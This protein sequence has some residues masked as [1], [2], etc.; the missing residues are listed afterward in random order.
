MVLF[1]LLIAG[2]IGFVYSM[3][4]VA[5]LVTGTT[6]MMRRGP[7]AGLAA[8]AGTALGFSIYAAAAIIGLGLFQYFLRPVHLAIL[9]IVLGVVFIV[10]SGVFMKRRRRRKPKPKS[11][12]PDQ[13]RGIWPYFATNLALILSGPQKI[14]Y[15]TGVFL[16]FKLHISSVDVK[17]AIPFLTLL[18]SL[19]FWSVYVLLVSKEKERLMN[20]RVVTIGLEKIHHVAHY[21]IFISTRN[22]IIE[23]RLLRKTWRLLIYAMPVFGVLL[24]IQGGAFFFH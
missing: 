10:T 15:I 9:E 22:F 24:I 3:M 8:G 20:L 12:A 4:S 14:A 7:V 18:G 5:T 11:K 6:G 13:K 2:A 23:K 1:K 17:V 16:F 21:K 19:A